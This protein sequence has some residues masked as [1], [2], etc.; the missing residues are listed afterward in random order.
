MQQ[1]R[2]PLCMKAIRL[3]WARCPAQNASPS[4]EPCPDLPPACLPCSFFCNTTNLTRGNTSVH[5][6][7]PLARLVR[8]SM[9]IVGLVPPVFHNEELLVDGGVSI[10]L[11][12]NQDSGMLSM[13]PLVGYP[14]VC[15]G[16]C[17]HWQDMRGAI[18]P[19]RLSRQGFSCLRSLDS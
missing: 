16:R 10:I 6:T 15:K 9:T 4:T 2:Q 14:F 1:L 7:G 11:G 18:A 5:S 12:E 17:S 13:H 8:A 3:Q 19:T